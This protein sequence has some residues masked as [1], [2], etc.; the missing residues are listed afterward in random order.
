MGA[1]KIVNAA[2]TTARTRGMILRD[3]M[4]KTPLNEWLTDVELSDRLSGTVRK[5]SRLGFK[6]LDQLRVEALAQTLGWI[7]ES[8]PSTYVT[9]GEPISEGDCKAITEVGWHADRLIS[10]NP[11]EE[12]IYTLKYI[13]VQDAECNVEREG[14]GLVLEQTSIQWIG[15]GR[16]CFALLTEYNKETRKWSECENPF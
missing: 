14:L 4:R 1:T 5:N 9:L 8:I 16:I 10:L 11:Y 13:I 15:A 6:Y 3:K 2:N 12:D 7:F